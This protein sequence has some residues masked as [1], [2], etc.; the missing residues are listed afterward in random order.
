MA[1]SKRRKFP[2]RT[3]L[4][5]TLLGAAALLVGG[6]LYRM[7]RSD[8]GLVRAARTFGF[9]DEPRLTAVVGRHVRRALDEAG[10]PRDSVQENVVEDGPTA[11]RWRVG[12]PADAS[13]LQLNHAIT[14]ALEDVGAAMLS[15]RESRGPNGT[16]VV[17]L[18]AGIPKRPTHEI[19]LVRQPRGDEPDE[20]PHARL[21]LVL[22]GFGDA[23][24]AADSFFALPSPFAVAITAGGKLTGAMVKSAHQYQREVVL[25]LPMEPINYPQVNPGAGTLLVTMRPARV[26][27]EVGRWLDQAKPVTAASNHMGSLATQDMTLMTAVYRELKQRRVPFLHLMPAAGAVCRPLASRMGVAYD[28]PDATLDFEPRANDTA[29]MDKRWKQVLKETRE[30]GRMIVWVRATPTTWRW[31]QKAL[32][33]KRLDRVDLVPLTSL[34][35]KPGPS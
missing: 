27:A 24:G 17:T 6:E 21:A 31:M 28:E 14:T 19:V 16:S 5:V 18:L 3:V 12:M 13:Q 11:V 20:R 8:S 32:D 25:H 2:L 26:G 9:V 1:R 7:S 34:L 33:A 10:V 15:G 29:T 30:R 4:L 35:R 23:L 22:Y